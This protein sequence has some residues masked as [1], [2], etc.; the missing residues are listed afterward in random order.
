MSIEEKLRERLK[1]S[2]LPPF[3][4]PQKVGDEIAGR[5]VRIRDSP[6]PPKTEYDKYIFEVQPLSGG[7]TVSLPL[8]ISLMRSIIE[9]GTKVGDYVMVR[10]TGEGKSS[11]GR[12]VKTYEVAVLPKEEAEE[13]A[14]QE[15]PQPTVPQTMASPSPQPTESGKEASDKLEKLEEIK[16]FVNELFSYYDSLTI[17]E[18]NYYLNTIKK[19]NIDPAIVIKELGLK[20]KGDKVTK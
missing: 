2:T 11:K 16:K 18:L 17:E 19:W 13:A 10:Y 4:K 7:E 12:T 20:V 3:W 1:K 6:W 15:T 8:H 5:V 9:E 14:P